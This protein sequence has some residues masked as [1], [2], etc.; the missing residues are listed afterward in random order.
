MLRD[1]RTFYGIKLNGISSIITKQKKNIKILI[2][3]KDYSDFNCVWYLSCWKIRG[4]WMQWMLKE[5][6]LIDDRRNTLE[7]TL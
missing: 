4:G 2:S 3:L 7:M 5:C 6:F 1:G